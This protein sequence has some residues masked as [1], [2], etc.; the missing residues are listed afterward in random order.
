MPKRK[1]VERRT[2]SIPADLDAR[3]AK[4]D[5]ENWSAIACRA[6]EQRL[7]EI[8]AQKVEKDMEDVVARLRASNQAAETELYAQGKEFGTRWAKNMATAIELRRL[9]KFAERKYND[10]DEEDMNSFLAP[11]DTDGSPADRLA[12]EILGDQG[13]GRNESTDFWHDA[14]GMDQYKSD[15]SEPEFLRGFIDGAV[16]IWEAVESRI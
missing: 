16:E 14:T 6:F 11:H 8:A 10:P 12:W 7:G 4:V 9:D 15:L 2:I 13:L 5:G 1:T 3:M